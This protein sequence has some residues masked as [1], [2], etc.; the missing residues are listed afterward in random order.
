MRIVQIIPGSGGGFYCENCLRDEALVRALH[1]LGHQPLMVPLYLPLAT[2]G[3]SPTE[4][5]EVF[6]GGVNVYLQQ[7]LRLFRRTPRWLDRLFDA[8]WLLRLAGR[9]AGMTSA[10]VLGETTL[11]M[12]RGEHG[13]QVKEL[14]RL[15]AFL[16]SQVR[17]DVVYLSNA[18]LLGLARRTRQALDAPVV[19]ALQDED[20]F[21][22]AL[23]EPYRQQAWDELAARAGDADGFIAVSRYYAEHMRRRLALPGEK[24]HVARMGIAAGGYAPAEAPPERP[25]VGYLSR[26]CSEK[27]I[28]ALVEAFVRLEERGR[29][30][31]VRLQAAGGWTSEDARLIRRLRRRLKRS[32]LSGR[33]EFLGNLTGPQRHAFLRSLSVVSVPAAHAEAFGM[34]VLEALASG[35]PVVQPRTGSFPEILDATGGGILYDPGDP[36]ALTDALEGLLADGERARRLG[37]A[38]RE[39]VLR[40]FTIERMAREVAGVCERAAGARHG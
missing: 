24:V 3:P 7:K 4:T 29:V 15:V 12:L 8:R 34:Y 25:T 28:D 5:Q 10:R 40:E 6:F 17:P 39:A 31:G 20:F 16:S 11:S 21:L 14:E 1:A 30:P 2:E 13:R 18:L 38:G 22:D 19:C 33:A 23:P 26:L 37:S 27:G 35:V 9:M 32:G 36:V